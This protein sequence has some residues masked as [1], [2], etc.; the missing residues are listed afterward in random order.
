MQELCTLPNSPLSRML[1]RNKGEHVA[2]LEVDER[3]H[4]HDTRTFFKTLQEAAGMPLAGS[5]NASSTEIELAV[6]TS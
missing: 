1:R 4:V 2:D 6:T 5:G 3:G